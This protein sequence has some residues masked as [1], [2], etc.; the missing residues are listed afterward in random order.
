MSSLVE[1]LRRNSALKTLAKAVAQLDQD[2]ASAAASIRRIA[3]KGL[4][5]AQ[6][7]LGLLYEKGKG[8]IPSVADAHRWYLAA[9][10]QGVPE[11]QAKLGEIYFS[12]LAQA[13]TEGQAE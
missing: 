12:G 7:Q 9:A 6:V 3:E 4:P 1:N 11:G 2:A 5:E 8:V 10:E 13:K